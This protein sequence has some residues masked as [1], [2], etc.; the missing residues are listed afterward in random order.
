M[1]DMS[2]QTPPFSGTP[3]PLNRRTLLQAAGLGAGVLAAGGLAAG[4]AA[5]DSGAA[6][7]AK[8]AGAAPAAAAASAASADLPLTGGPDF[9]IGLF[10][11]PHPFETTL[12]RYQEISDAGFTF[13]I[14]GNYQFDEQSGGWALKMADQTGLKVL[15]AG[16]PRIE[17][18]AHYMSVTD[19]RSVPS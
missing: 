5:A 7:G 9:P 3:R 19:D 2:E 8:P 12:E 16:D 14:T 10:W 17:A 11:P 1:S 13:L 6:A 15:I 18:I 4:R